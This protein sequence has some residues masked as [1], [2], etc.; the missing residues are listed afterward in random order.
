[1]RNEETEM[2]VEGERRWIGFSWRLGVRISD[3]VK[4]WLTQRRNAAKVGVK[5]QQART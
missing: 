5:A 3:A 4:A 1:M 2:D